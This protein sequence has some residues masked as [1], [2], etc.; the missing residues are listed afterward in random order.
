MNYYELL[1]VDDKCSP[2]NIRKAFLNKIRFCHPDK[3]GDAKEAQSLIEAYKVL[4]NC[5]EEYNQS[6]R[7]Q[8]KYCF[9]IMTVKCNYVEYECEQ[10]GEEN[11]I[12][13]NSQ[14]NVIVECRSCN[15]KLQIF[16]Q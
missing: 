2:E 9:D 10:C 16:Q 3:N 15:L 1:G 6:L 4:M 11:Q 14:T 7:S 12:E 8:F 5:R 13:L